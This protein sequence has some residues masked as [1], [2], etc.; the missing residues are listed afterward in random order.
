MDPS[1]WWSL[2]IRIAN[3]EKG[4]AEAVPSLAR[5]ESDYCFGV[6][7][8]CSLMA[9]EDFFE[10]FAEVLVEDFELAAAPFVVPATCCAFFR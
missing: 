9:E 5:I 3:Q 2:S 10:A 4:T 1:G 7:G 8:G 6:T